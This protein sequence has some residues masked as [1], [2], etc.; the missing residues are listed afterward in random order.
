MDISRNEL[1]YI[2]IED[3]YYNIM[4]VLKN[5]IEFLFNE[6]EK[7]KRLIEEMNNKILELE[8]TQ[9]QTFEETFWED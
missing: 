7:Q 2:S 6:L 1:S 3:N 8:K 5:N 4:A 9:N